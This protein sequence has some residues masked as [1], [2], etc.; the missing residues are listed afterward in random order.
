MFGNSGSQ[1]KYLLPETVYH[2]VSEI[3]GEVRQS[4]S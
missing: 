4:S 1:G 2:C 3:L